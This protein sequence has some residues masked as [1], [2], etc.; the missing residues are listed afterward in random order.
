LLATPQH[1]G[2]PSTVL[3][4][5]LEGT[6]VI[7]RIAAQHRKLRIDEGRDA[8]ARAAR[9]LLALADSFDGVLP[10]A[11]PD[12]GCVVI[13]RPEVAH[14]AVTRE[15]ARVG[16]WRS[17]SRSRGGER[18]W[19]LLAQSMRSLPS[20]RAATERDIPVVILQPEEL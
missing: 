15:V 13:D 10:V 18:L 7:H 14:G 6:R 12:V 2:F 5:R 16:R 17:S 9:T 8:A 4:R 20:Y 1:G 11:G 19:P 3:R